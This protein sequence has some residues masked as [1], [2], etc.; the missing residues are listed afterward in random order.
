[1]HPGQYISKGMSLG[2][3]WTTQ[4]HTIEGYAFGYT[5]DSRFTHAH[6]PTFNGHGGEGGGHKYPS[7]QNNLPY[8]SPPCDHGF[9]NNLILLLGLNGSVYIEN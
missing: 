5:R 1:M 8:E 7:P 4:M 2:S 6:D 9:E 3:T